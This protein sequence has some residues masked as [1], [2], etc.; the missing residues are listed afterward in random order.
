MCDSVFRLHALPAGNGDAVVIE[1]GKADHTGPIASAAE[2]GRW[3]YPLKHTSF[4]WGRSPSSTIFNGPARWP[5]SI[6]VTTSSCKAAFAPRKS[7]RLWHTAIDKHAMAPTD[8][9]D[10]LIVVGVDEGGRFHPVD[11]QHSSQ[12]SQPS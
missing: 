7:G 12:A 2:S 9:Q 3:R 6:W 4:G 5:L 11:L 1:Y 10:H 8:D